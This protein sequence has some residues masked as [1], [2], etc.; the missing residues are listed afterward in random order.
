MW[1]LSGLYTSEDTF[2]PKHNIAVSTVTL[3]FHAECR[4]VVINSLPLSGAHSQLLSQSSPLNL[5]NPNEREVLYGHKRK[6][7]KNKEKR[8]K[9][10]YEGGRKEGGQ[11]G[12]PQ[13]SE[14]DS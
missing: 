14:I 13:H 2:D 12:E 5:G 10:S 6:K 7:K 8:K 9:K 3:Q 11:D 4:T 1:I